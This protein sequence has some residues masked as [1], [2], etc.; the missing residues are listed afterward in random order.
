M[1]YATAPRA[2]KSSERTALRNTAKLDGAK[3]SPRKKTDTLQYTLPI[4][5][6]TYPGAW[7]CEKY[8][9]KWCCWCYATARSLKML[10]YYAGVR[11]SRIL[12]VR[13]WGCFHLKH[14]A[15]ESTSRLATELARM[16]WAND[17]GTA[18]GRSRGRDVRKRCTLHIR[19]QQRYLRVRLITPCMIRVVHA[20]SRSAAG[21]EKQDSRRET[22]WTRNAEERS[23]T[24]TRDRHKITKQNILQRHHMTPHESVHA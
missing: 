4:N 24:D 23:E 17:A 10:L 8:D 12:L 21:A 6:L 16:R 5:A 13:R 11:S 20:R 22:V 9:L 3:P 7:S 2:T 1:I 19:Q 14:A 18:A 15:V